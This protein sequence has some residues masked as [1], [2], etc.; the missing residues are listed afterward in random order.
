MKIKK[1]HLINYRNYQNLNI[2]FSNTLNLI[3]GDNGSGKSNLVEAIYLLSLTKSFRTTNDLNLIREKENYMMVSGDIESNNDKTNYKLELNSE[4]KKVYIDEDK[5]RKISDYISHI[6]III[7]NP[8][9]SK[10]ISDSPAVRR[11]MLDIEISQINREYLIL[12]S[13]YN[14]ILKHRNAYLKQLYLNGNASRDY[15][16][17]LTTKLINIGIKIC[18][19]RQN[20]LDMINEQITKIYQN[21]FEVGELQ[22]KYKSSYKNK[23]IKDILDMYKKN[24]V[25]EIS[26]GKTLFG[27]HHDD[28]EFILDKKSIKEYGS[29]GQQKNAIISFKLSEIVIMKKVTN[30]YPILILDDLFS[31]L[32]NK[33]INN[34]ISMLNKDVQ[35]FITTTD[36]ENVDKKLIEDSNIYYV[37]E[38]NIER[39]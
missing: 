38:G 33:K 2:E 9:D 3:Y 11:K 22:V 27:I 29:V 6:N 16:D 30:E 10:I 39:K 7:F 15:L 23:D 34:I 1:L 19:I 5:I 4:G 8:L 37:N 14:K 31:E 18:E 17:I 20:Y 13:S 36:I 26:I 24:Y 25:K 35:T 32:D 28:F 21:I 12:I